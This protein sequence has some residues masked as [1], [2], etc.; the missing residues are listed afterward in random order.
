MS[1]HRLH[2]IQNCSLLP[3]C[4]ANKF[5]FKQDSPPQN[6]ATGV[7]HYLL[8]LADEQPVHSGIRLTCNIQAWSPVSSPDKPIHSPV[9]SISLQIIRVQGT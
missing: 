9:R 4:A 2:E 6:S 1:P 8:V 7:Q 5:S 3:H